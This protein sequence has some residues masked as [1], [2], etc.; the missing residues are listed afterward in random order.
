MV[1]GDYSPEL[2][3]QGDKNRT[4]PNR[5]TSDRQ[6]TTERFKSRKRQ[7]EVEGPN[8]SRLEKSDRVSGWEVVLSGL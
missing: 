2:Q 1:V 7:L 4:T 3:F 5:D 6:G 8:F